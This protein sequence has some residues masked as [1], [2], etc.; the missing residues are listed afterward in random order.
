MIK[1]LSVVFQSTPTTILDTSDNSNASGTWFPGAV[2]NIA[3]CC[4]R[5][6]DFQKKTDES[7]AILWR[8]EGFD[9]FP[10]NYLSLKDLRNQVMYDIL[11]QITY[12]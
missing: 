12:H 9:D 8:N 5:P 4:I 1:E 6:V 11:P 2:L 10:I 3:E 7:A